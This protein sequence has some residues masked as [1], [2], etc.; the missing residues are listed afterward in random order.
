M[1]STKFNTP[2][3]VKI[4]AW[5]KFGNSSISMG[6]VIII[7][8]FKKLSTFWPEKQIFFR[9]H[10][11]FKVSNLGLVVYLRL[12]LCFYVS[13]FTY[14]ILLASIELII[15]LYLT[16]LIW[17][18]SITMFFSV[19]WLHFQI[20]LVTWAYFCTFSLFRFAFNCFFQIRFHIFLVYDDCSGTVVLQ[21]FW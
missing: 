4:K 7:T 14:S 9:K 19:F 5:R 17:I 13:L 16:L 10:F 20:L 6:E 11:K 15:D 2:G 18:I 21:Q 1:I 3:L 12:V 8:I